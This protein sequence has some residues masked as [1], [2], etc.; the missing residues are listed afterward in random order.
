M[1]LLNKY[2]IKISFITFVVLLI[3]LLGFFPG[4]VSYDG[5]NQWQQVQSGL[6][7]D[8]HPFFSTFFMYLLSKIWN[9]VTIVILFQI[10]LF[11]ISWGYLCKILKLSRKKQY[12][13]MYIVTICILL[14]PLTSLYSITLWK[15]ILYTN[16]LFLCAIMLYD[17]PNNAY[18]L[19]N[20]KYVILGIVIFMIYSF[21]H[22]GII[23]AILLLLFFYIIC[24]KNYK[25]N[26]I[27]KQNLKKSFIVLIS[28]FTMIIVISVPKKIILEKS[29]NIIANQSDYKE[30]YSTID[31][32]M[33]WMMGAHIKDNNIDSKKDK[34][35]LNKI[36]PIEEWKKIY[37]PYLI[38][39]THNDRNLDREFVI[40]NKTEFE[41]LFIKYSLKHPATILNHYLKSDS[42]LINPV[43]SLDGY[44]YVYCFPEMESLPKYTEIR[45]IIP[46]IKDIYIKI[47]DLSFIKPFIII[48]EPAFI[49]YL[50]IILTIIL[51]KKIFGKKIW[52]FTIPMFLNI[53][54]LIPINLAQDLRYVYINYLTFYGLILMF[55]LN[56]NKIR[57]KKKK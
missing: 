47:S 52:F 55:I 14:Y 5:N 31:G 57:K 15:D 34:E 2:Y 21:R 41:N 36:I 17:W 23:V 9:S 29:H 24:I 49:L 38:N 22:N 48:Y 30:S 11:S 44:V 19:N 26:I 7:T 51:S 54:S 35:F 50:S 56:L 45:P 1:K 42:L 39:S 40:N 4:I 25:K 3:I 12:I 37:N 53:V 28:F 20:K 32:Y 6:I 10:V 27:D 43:S 33:L 46:F 13:I 16:Y 8:A 18:C